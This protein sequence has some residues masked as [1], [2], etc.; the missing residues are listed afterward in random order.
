M[1]KY[2]YMLVYFESSLYTFDIDEFKYIIR[3]LQS[4]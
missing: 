2:S 3:Q 1:S 4:K